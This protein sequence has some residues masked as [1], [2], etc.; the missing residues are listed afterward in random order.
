MKKRDAPCAVG[1]QL[2]DI[3]ESVVRVLREIRGKQNVFVEVATSGLNTY[4]SCALFHLEPHEKHGFA[5]TVNDFVSD[6]TQQ[7][8][9]HHRVALGPDHDERVALLGGDSVDFPFCEAG[10]N[11]CL[12]VESLLFEYFPLLAKDAFQRGSGVRQRGRSRLLKVEAQQKQALFRPVNA[13]SA[14]AVYDSEGRGREIRGNDKTLKH[15]FFSFPESIGLSGRLRAIRRARLVVSARG[16]DSHA[17]RTQ[18]KK[19]A[20]C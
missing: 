13:Q 9:A 14:E 19:D 20:L 5:S 11:S 10:E 12:Y 15:G 1:C 4:I 17:F 8:F 2:L 16:S 7:R 3:G 18:A 6:A